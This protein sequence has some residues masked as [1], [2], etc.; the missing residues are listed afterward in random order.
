MFV[1]IRSS[2]VMTWTIGGG[3]SLFAET[4]Y[5]LKTG[6]ACVP[7]RSSGV[8]TWTRERWVVKKST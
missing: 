1:P 2:G 6:G 4:S 8:M 3:L 7:I 5:Q